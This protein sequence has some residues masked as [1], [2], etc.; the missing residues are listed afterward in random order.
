MVIIDDFLPLITID[1]KE[2]LLGANTFDSELWAPLIEKA[3]AKIYNGYFTIGLGGD[4]AN[5]LT[6]LTGAP[7]EVFHGRFPA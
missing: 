3:Y 7:T 5:A 1:G 6:D 2:K 4:V